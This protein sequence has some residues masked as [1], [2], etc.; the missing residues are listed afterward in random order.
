MAEGPAE[1][2]ETESKHLTWQARSERGFWTQTGMD[3]SAKELKGLAGGSSAR[4]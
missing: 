3:G 4:G 1:M 2:Q